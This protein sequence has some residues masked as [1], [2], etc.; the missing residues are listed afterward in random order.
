LVLEPRDRAGLQEYLREIYDPSSPDFHHFLSV[1]EFRQ[2]FGPAG[3]DMDAAIAYAAANNLEVRGVAANGLL[4]TVNASVAQIQSAFHV[5]IQRYQLP[6]ESRTFFSTDREPSLPSE[7][8]ISHIVGL[9]DYS[10]PQPQVCKPLS[11]GQAISVNGSGP[12]GSYLGSDMRAA[13]YGGAQL[14]GKGQSLALVQFGGYAIEDVTASFAGAAS[15]R[16]NRGSYI[17]NYRPDRTG[18][19]YTVPIN[20]V[21]LDGMSGA[22]E[23]DDSEEV[24]DIVQAVSMAPGL[25]Q[26]R[27][28]IGRFDVDILNAVAS[29]DAA[30]QVSISWG[31]T[32]DDPGIIDFLFQEM[33]AQ[34]QSV[35]AASGNH[36]GGSV[37]RLF[38]AE[39]AYVTAVGGT[40]LTTTGLGG[41]WASET[42]WDASA[43]GISPDSV[44][45]PY[46]QRGLATT[47][48]RASSVY[49]NIPDVAMEA[50]SDNY[51][52]SHG[53]CEGGWA[54]TSFASPRWAAYAA[55]LNEAATAQGRGPVGFLNPM[56]LAAGE[57]PDYAS[58]FHDVTFGIN[59][60]YAKISGFFAVP[61]YDLVTG[62]GTPA[63]PEILAL[64][65]STNSSDVQPGFSPSASGLAPGI[66]TSAAITAV[67]AGVSP[68]SVAF[69]IDALPPGITAAVSQ[70]ATT[71]ASVVALTAQ[72]V[73]AAI[74]YTTDGSTPTAGSTLY[75][76]AITVNGKK[77]I[78]AIADGGN[79]Q[80]DVFSVSFTVPSATP[81][82]S[83]TGGTYT[84]AQ[85]VTLSDSTPG[86][87]IYYTTDGTVPTTTSMLYTGPITVAST[88]TITAMATASGYSQSSLASAAYT[89]NTTAAT[90]VL[91][92]GSGTYTS[93]QMVA[94]SDST[95]GA[96]IYYTTDGSV[97]TTS[98]IVYTGPIT[99]EST[100]TITAM[101][102]ASGY[103]QS[104]LASAAYT[105]NATAAVI[106]TLNTMAPLYVAAKGGSFRLSLW[107]A[108]FTA[109]STA[110]WGSN[111][112][113]TEFVSETE[114]TVQVPASAIDNAG[115]FTVTVQ[116]QGSS[117]NLLQFEVDSAPPS[118]PSPQFQS[119]SLTVPAGSAASFSFTV[120]DGTDPVSVNCLNLPMG[121]TCNLAES[122]HAV[123]VSTLSATPSG[124]YNTTVVF[125]ET[126]SKLGTGLLLPFVA[127]FWRR[128]NSKGWRILQCL[129]LLLVVA[130]FATACS[131]VSQPQ[132]KVTTSEAITI[133]V[134]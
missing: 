18:T 123:I 11:N 61:G 67:D 63:G 127:L 38:P 91:S 2:R 41:K 13:Y 50:D 73:G 37:P 75:T 77:T 32:P 89:I 119:Q 47:A 14:T 79:P 1:A 108:H 132:T 62:W 116:N 96:M 100:Q 55:L 23:M 83:P 51:S 7:L 35:F 99:V 29:E 78:K 12:G 90:P 28:Y 26:V 111:S 43:G 125:T 30:S 33:A 114:L 102:T 34:G 97:P 126:S 122:G 6:T 124:T 84:S 107:G 121:T 82:I 10:L 101:A 109:D 27:V 105:I 133:G 85:T 112:L 72:T 98:S 39:S 113:A 65:G 53:V 104:S 118:F 52:C 54:G 46:W 42:A 87:T 80:S 21:V 40:S 20:N 110:F 3:E 19:T 88:Q 8:H 66:A 81:V 115:T 131:K 58:S 24:L 134:S 31:W 117:S 86:A 36:C 128:R 57:G 59:S 64:L 74:H 70:D 22:A 56:L 71:S 95:P 103:S 76:Q 120:P 106:P 129:V 9:N 93:A 44:P 92:L 15:A 17:L 69:S 25:S 68:T 49:R 4:L 130:S 16:A 94:L 45:L 60:D 5:L 48:N